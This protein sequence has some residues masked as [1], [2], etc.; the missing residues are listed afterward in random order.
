[1]VGAGNGETNV[2]LVGVT[3]VG[4]RIGG[5]ER[6]GRKGHELVILS[7]GDRKVCSQGFVQVTARGPYLSHQLWNGHLLV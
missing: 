3:G 7:P 4:S 1:M 2:V 5:V 6:I